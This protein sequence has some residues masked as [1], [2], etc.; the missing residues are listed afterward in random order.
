M[1]KIGHAAHQAGVT[2]ETVRYY[3]REG[4][5]N[6]AHRSE[7][8][9]RLYGNAD[10]ERLQF[11]RKAKALGFALDDIAELLQLQ[12]G[13]GTQDQIKARVHQRL[14]DLEHKIKQLTAIH[15]ALKTLE[16]RCAGCGPIAGCAIIEGVKAISLVA[17]SG[18][19]VPSHA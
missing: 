2:V 18:D 19:S 6:T 5:L 1:H 16:D 17:P 15:A 11:I 3:E 4:L 7:S 10:I 8:G 13:G 14:I 12:D 9:Y